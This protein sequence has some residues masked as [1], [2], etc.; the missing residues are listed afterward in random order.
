MEGR[1]WILEKKNVVFGNGS[2]V[3]YNK[4]QWDNAKISKQVGEWMKDDISSR[5]KNETGK[6]K[7]VST[8]LHRES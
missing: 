4:I 7:D 6:E 8:N 2:N 3:M 1:G 5:T